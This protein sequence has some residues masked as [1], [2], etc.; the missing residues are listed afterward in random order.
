MSL[1]WLV[2]KVILL[3]WYGSFFR[4]HLLE[5]PKHTIELMKKHWYKDNS[6]V[7][8]LCLSY[9]TSN[10]IFFVCLCLLVVCFFIPS[11]LIIINLKIK[12]KVLLL[13]CWSLSWLDTFILFILAVEIIKNSHFVMFSLLILIPPTYKPGVSL[14][15]GQKVTKQKDENEEV[16]FFPLKII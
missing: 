10:Y 7:N 4:I 16:F 9:Q 11:R 6:C 12:I 2:V 1:F 14:F 13:S 5:L 8:L 3:W 15:D